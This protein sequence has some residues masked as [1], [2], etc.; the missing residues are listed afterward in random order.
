MEKLR[1]LIERA[2]KEQKLS[3]AEIV[4]RSGGRIKDSYIFDIQS[5]K[6]KSISVQK[7][8]ALADGLGVNRVEL[9]MLVSGIEEEESWTPQSLVRAIQKMIHLKPNEI[10]QVKKILKIE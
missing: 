2:I 9:Y 5:G 8:N 6:T 7:L 3:V 10:R 4:R 1:E